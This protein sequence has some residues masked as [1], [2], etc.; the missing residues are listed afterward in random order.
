MFCG[1]SFTPP[2]LVTA[3][4]AL[5]LPV[6]IGYGLTEATTVVTVGRTTPVRADTVGL[7]VSGV[8]VR[9]DAPGADGVGEV[10][11]RGP[12][13]MRG[14]LDDPE[15]TA[16]VLRDGW[17]H[18]GDLGW[19]DASGHLRLCGRLKD[20]IVTAGGKNVWPEDVEGAFRDAG[21][22][23]V[24]VFADHALEGRRSLG[25]EHLVLV[26]RRERGLDGALDALR[27]AN[28]GLPDYQRV[29]LA[30]PWGRPFPRTATL[31]LR[32]TELREQVRAAGL[33]GAVPLR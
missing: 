14:Y 22:D 4:D 2:H 18:T 1:G 10:C 33:D 28:R 19:F 32:R 24:A 31:K 16:E 23:E 30:L 17:L 21:C 12:T 7:P 11:V 15:Q 5:G 29:S 6:V 27:E 3:F 8:E 25:D 20:L 9:I 26:V 13:V